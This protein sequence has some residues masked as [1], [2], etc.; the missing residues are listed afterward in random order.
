MSGRKDPG[1]QAGAKVPMLAALLK[2]ID[3]FIPSS[4]KSERS[5]LALA[6]NFVFTHL[7]GPAMAQP[8][9]LFLYKTDPQPGVAVWTIM[10][11]ISAFWALPFALKW[12]KSL[13]VAALLSVELLTFVTLFGSFHYGGVSS[14]FAPWLIIALML[15]FFYLSG[16]PL[17]VITL[18]GANLLGFYSAYLHNGGHFAERVPLSAL[19]SVAMISVISA[20]VYMAWMAVYYASMMSLRSEL[21]KEEERHRITAILES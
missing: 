17:V 9:G 16:K 4:T 21:Q 13:Q 10:A 15:G 20:T 19:S 7:F 5:E 18:L 11:C 12:G 14:P 3:W 8:I 1:E 2:F 6:R